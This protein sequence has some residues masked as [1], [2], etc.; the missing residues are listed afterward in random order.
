[1][2]LTMQGIDMFYEN[3][4]Q[5]KSQ[6]LNELKNNTNKND[7]KADKYNT[8]AISTMTNIQVNLLKLK[9]IIKSKED[10]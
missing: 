10:R 4:E 5:C 1:M 3:L 6:C 9:K 7:D 8:Q 2:N